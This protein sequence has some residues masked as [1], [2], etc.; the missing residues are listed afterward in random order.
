M[1]VIKARSHHN[2]DVAHNEFQTYFVRRR[3]WNRVNESLTF[4]VVCS[5][6]LTAT[7]R[8]G[9]QLEGYNG[10]EWDQC[11][12]G[13]HHWDGDH[14]TLTSIVTFS[15]SVSESAI[16][17]TPLKSN[18]LFTQHLIG[19][20]TRSNIILKFS[21]ERVGVGLRLGTRQLEITI[22]CRSLPSW[23]LEKVQKW[24]G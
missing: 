15:V 16:M 6:R 4:F 12:L 7:A 21:Q 22:Q 10:S 13:I 17:N 23:R 8:W 9:Q 14:W 19:T 5:H 3:R 2:C 1:T 24:F 20:G 11:K 18:G